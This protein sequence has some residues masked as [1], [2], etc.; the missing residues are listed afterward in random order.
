MTSTPS[1]KFKVGDNVRYKQG[2]PR[3]PGQYKDVDLKVDKV[4]KTSGEITFHPLR[5]PKDTH[6]TSADRLEISPKKGEEV[7]DRSMYVDMVKQHGIAQTDIFITPDICKQFLSAF[8]GSNVE[9]WFDPCPAVTVTWDGLKIN[10]KSP[11]FV[12]PPVSFC[13]RQ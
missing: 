5:K 7:V 13:W 11:A 12:N 4:S 1:P 6:K 8:V 10:W 9:E 2:V 3:L